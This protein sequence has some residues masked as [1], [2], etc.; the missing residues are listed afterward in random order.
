[1]TQTE[2]NKAIIRRFFG[3]LDEGNSAV[4]E[5]VCAPDYALHFSGAPGSLDRAAARGLFD[6]FFAAFPG[7]QHPIEDMVAEVEKVS[8]R[9]KVQGTH[10][11]NF[12]GIPATG[13]EVTMAAIDIFR[14]E[15]GK[16][17]EQWVEF[18][19]LGLMQQLGAIPSPE[20]GTS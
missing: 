20:Q 4:I 1:M 5:D 8:V 3:E 16:V 17:V 2:V 7:I 11:G 12:Q 9:L 18:D 6:G 19:A 15:G 13:K 10:Q 14:I